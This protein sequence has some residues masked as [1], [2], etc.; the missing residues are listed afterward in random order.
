MSQLS[1]YILL[2]LDSIA[3]FFIV[4][5]A[6][7][8]SLIGLSLMVSALFVADDGGAT[9]KYVR[10]QLKWA[11]PVAIISL[12]IHLALPST[13]QMAAIIVVPKVISGIEKNEELMSLPND[14]ANF[15]SSWIKELRPKNARESAKIIVQQPLSDAAAK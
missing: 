1:L 11:L 10:P 2:K 7:L 9:W 14:I 4:I 3:T 13:K 6:T 8:F 5:Y 12:L 15:A